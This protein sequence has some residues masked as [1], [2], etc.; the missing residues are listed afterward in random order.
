MKFNSIPAHSFSHSPKLIT[1]KNRN[2]GP[3]D[4]TPTKTILYNEP[5][6]KIGTQKRHT[7]DI[8]NESP[9]PGSYSIPLN[10]SLGPKYSMKS[11]LDLIED[12]TKIDFPGPGAYKP[13]YKS[14][15]Y[16]YSFGKKNKKDNK[17]F[18]TT[19]G[20]GNYNLRKEKEI[21]SPS[22]LFGK[23][24][25]ENNIVKIKKYVP[26]PGTY[27]QNKQYV[28]IRN[29]KYTFGLKLKGKNYN[30]LAPGPGAYNFR[31]LIGQEG[32]KITMGKKLNYDAIND[33]STP[34]PGAYKESRINFYK[35]QSPT[36]KLGKSKRLFELLNINSNPGPGQYSFIEGENYTK[37]KSPS[38]KIGT[39]LRKSLS[40]TDISFPGVGNYNISG[41]LGDN[42]PKY[43]I[44][45]K[46][47][48]T[49]LKNENPGPGQYEST[50]ITNMSLYNRAPS[51]KLGTENRYNELRKTI[52]EDIPGPGKYHPKI[53]QSFND[54]YKYK[55]GIKKRFSRHFNDNPGPG[56]Y[57]IPCSI[58]DV[59]NYS[60]DKGHFDDKYK[61]I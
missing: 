20:P 42:A 39:S 6:W 60:R 57:H 15:S 26:G 25:R 3:G 54:N 44:R 37:V 32:T 35:K 48:I 22:Y 12:K 51:W 29:P 5:R 7:L 61:F 13:L 14:T 45:L 58:V 53:N 47:F 16:F 59:M 21:T 18:D 24:K 52:R 43:S 33:K 50:N 56:A 36:P 1:P 55:F 10:I 30:T 28:L 46:N 9:G 23:E 17:K 38:W 40:Q 8:N 31:Q 41:K 2:P 49:K 11:K 19:P 27:E 4:Y 34:G